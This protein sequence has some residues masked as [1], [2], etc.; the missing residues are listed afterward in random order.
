MLPAR[1]FKVEHKS[2]CMARE[3]PRNQLSEDACRGDPHRGASRS[4]ARAAKI[5]EEGHGTVCCRLG[6]SWGSP[7][8]EE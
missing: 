2:L 7:K 6:P 1:L 8:Q 4:E 5:G 3:V